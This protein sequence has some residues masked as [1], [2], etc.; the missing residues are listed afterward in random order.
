MTALVP[1]VLWKFVIATQPLFF[2]YTLGRAASPGV[3]KNEIWRWFWGVLALSMCC[4]WVVEN[5]PPS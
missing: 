1:S 5:W 3:Y 2:G 4:D